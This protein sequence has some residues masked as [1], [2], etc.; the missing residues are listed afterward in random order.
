MQIMMF[1][2]PLI[3]IGMFWYGWAAEE[4]VHWYSPHETPSPLF[5]WDMADDRI[6]PILG[7]VPI[8]IGMIGF[9]VFS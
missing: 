4:R 9:F 6:V 8:G 1:F 7:T 2:T 5:P 3:A